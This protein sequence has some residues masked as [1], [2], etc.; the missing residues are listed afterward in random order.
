MARELF[1][2]SAEALFRYHVVSVVLAA[3]LGGEGV[4]AAVEKAAQQTHLTLR[5]ESRDVDERTVWRWLSAWKSNGLSGLEPDPREGDGAGS[6][7]PPALLNYVLSQ[8]QLDGRASIPELLRRSVAAGVVSSLDDV[9]RVTVWRA[10]KQRGQQTLRRPSRQERDVRRWGYA[11][12]M[13][14]TLCDGKHFRVGARRSR[15]VGLFFLDDATRRGLGVVVGMSESTRLFLNVLFD[16]VSEV[17]MMDVAYLDRGSGFRSDDT[18]VVL[19]QLGIARVLGEARYPEGHGKIEKFN[20]TATH[21]VL[22]NLDGRAEVDDG[23]GSLTL[24]LRHYLMEVYNHTPHESLG[25]KTPQQCW[26]ADERKLVFPESMVNLRGRFVLHEKRT[27]TADNVVPVEGVHY[28]VPRGHAR[29]VLVVQ[30]HVLDGTVSIQ[31]DGHLVKLHPVDRVAN[32]QA[33]RAH[34]TARPEEETTPI[35]PPTAAEMMWRKDFAPVVGPDG[36]YLPG[37]SNPNNDDDKET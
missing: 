8:K 32:A 37:L 27:V 30:R 18:A 19:A 21:A 5:G 14:M 33:R 35:L 9:D 12:R 1:E 36:G 28:E 2:A 31:H 15:R 29:S 34:H 11:H 13:Q 26:D 6:S 16:V 7:L 4:S 25:G 20:Q 24:R 22:R 17:G 10:L 23:L 3:V